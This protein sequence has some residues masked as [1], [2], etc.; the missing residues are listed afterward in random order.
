MFTGIKSVPKMSTT[1]AAYVAEK[2]TRVS[3][4]GKAHHSLVPA[5]VGFARWVRV[6][7][8]RM[9]VWA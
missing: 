6:L 7:P 8:I 4:S 2:I 3:Y 9:R 1:T 5:L